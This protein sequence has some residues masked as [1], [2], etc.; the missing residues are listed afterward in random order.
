MTGAPA[1]SPSR[2]VVR[3]VLGSIVFT[4]VGLVLFGLIAAPF[5]RQVAGQGS[6][7]ELARR[8]PVSLVLLQAVG[9]L[10]GFGIATW[11][12]G[13]RGLRL[14][15]RALRW[16]TSLGW[17]RGFGAGLVLGLLPAAVAMLLGVVVGAS[18]W[19]PDGGSLSEY[20]SRVGILLLLLAPAALAEEV[21]FRGV[22][23]VLFAEAIGRPAAMVALSLI[24]ALAHTGNP[25][26]TIQALGNITLAGILLSLAFYSPGGMWAAFGAHLGWNLT[27][28]LL[29]APVSGLPFDVPM[30]DYSMG[31]PGWLTGGVFGPEGG[32]LSTL[33]LT[34][35]I[36]L[37]VRWVRRHPA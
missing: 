25:D 15:L 33:T 27:L 4:L 23:L 16:R 32:L 34:T 21:I 10:F 14:D 19:V 28:A 37:A 17:A 6:I 18:A 29:G 7:E 1:L 31:R 24:F 30:I 35:A 9:M 3:A 2:R 22:P 11:L 12:V 36:I 20:L 13:V 26:V 8:P 5:A